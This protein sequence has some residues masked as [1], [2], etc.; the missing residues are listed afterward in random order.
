MNLASIWTWNGRVNRGTY[1]L[2]G[3][4]GVVI[5]HN[6]DRLLANE[7]GL[8]W[9][10]WNY[11]YALEGSAHPNSLTAPSR[12]FLAALLLTALPFIWIGVAMTMKRLRDA[13]QPLWLTILFFAPIVNLLFFAVLCALPSQESPGKSSGPSNAHL[14][15]ASFW[16]KSRWGSAVVGVV[17]AAVLGTALAWFDLRYFGNYG[18][19]LFIAL[20]FVMGYLAVWVHC[21]T[22][23]RKMSDVLAVVSFSVLL[24]GA[25]ITAIALEGLICLAM[26]A[27]IA[28]LLACFGGFLAYTIHNHPAVQRP[29][30]A[31][32]A[33]LVFALPAMMGAEHFAP[34][35]VPRYQVRTSIEIAAP[36]ELVWKRIIAFPPL[37]DAKEWPFRLGIAYPIEARLKGEGLTADRECR[38]ST[39]NFK[40][41]ILAWE[42]GRHF[43]FA[44]AEDPLLMKETSPY[45]NIQVRHLQDHDFQP[46]RADFVLIALPDGGTRLE[47]TT[48]YQNKMWPG[49]YW[50]LWTD[51]IVHSIH[52]RVFVHVKELSEEDA[53][54]HASLE[55][56]HPGQLPGK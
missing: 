47:G 17:I 39:G 35:P 29:A 48:T 6:L 53:R 52:R 16:P 9:H 5:K 46:E 15:P 49:A 22:Q 4:L 20:P 27:P 25:G 44:V 3:F 50:R 40:E 10:I 8:Q 13:G 33:V 12:Q 37:T 30:N 34:P 18:L 54:S 42:P 36:P 28:W 14:V 41:P 26:A 32:F 56:A 51:A 21:R 19:S 43:A 55:P 31:T 11:W 23:P 45:G 7:S 1:A 38:F 24:A 2:A